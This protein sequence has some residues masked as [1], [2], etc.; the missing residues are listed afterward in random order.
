MGKAVRRRLYRTRR[1]TRSCGYVSS[2]TRPLKLIIS[3]IAFAETRLPVSKQRA[4]I[5]TLR[6][7]T[8]RAGTKSGKG[9]LR[10]PP[11]GKSAAGVCQ[12]PDARDP[13]SPRIPSR[14]M[15]DIKSLPPLASATGGG[16]C[17]QHR[18]L[19]TGVNWNAEARNLWKRAHFSLSR[20]EIYMVHEG[21]GPVRLLP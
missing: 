7:P 2:V 20:I 14:P 19:K 21:S 15:G 5:S 13:R 11:L 17:L 3:I 8:D 12:K 9:Q 18:E 4:S 1:M 6:R 16:P 10:P